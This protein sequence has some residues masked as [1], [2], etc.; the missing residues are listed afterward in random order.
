MFARHGR[1]FFYPSI[2]EQPM[3]TF[4]SLCRD[5]GGLE[6]STLK[7]FEFPPDKIEHATCAAAFAYTPPFA[8]RPYVIRLNA[9]SNLVV[10]TDRRD[11]DTP[12]ARH[13]N[14]G[15]HWECVLGRF[16]DQT[17]DPN[18][19][20]TIRCLEAGDRPHGWAVKKLD[21]D[22]GRR[23]SG[24]I[25]MVLQG[26][27]Y[28][29]LEAEQIMGHLSRRPWQLVSIPFAPEEDSAART[30]NTGAPQYVYQPIPGSTAHWDMIFDHVGFDLDAYLPKID[31]RDRRES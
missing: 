12:P 3:S 31:W 26:L 5:H 4:R 7:G 24:D 6:L 17:A 18:L 19:D 1:P 15:K 10:R 27:G 30:W 2:N 20:D 9:Q 13:I 14:T 8:D 25:K 16:F 23:G 21:G 22:W 28:P 11:T 29:K